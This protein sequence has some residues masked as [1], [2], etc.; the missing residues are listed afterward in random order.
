MPPH[1][2][3]PIQLRALTVP[4]RIAVAPMCQYSATDGVPEDWHL[5]NLGRFATAGPGLIFTEATGVEPDGRIT[6][7]CTGMYDDTTEAAWARIVGFIKS[8]GDSRVGMQLGHSGRKGNTVPPWEGGGLLEGEGAW[9]PQS[10][11]AVAYLPGWPEPEAMGPDDL[12]RVRNAFADAARRA[13][14]AGFDTV[15][16]H[17]AHGYLLHQFLSPVTNRRDDAYGGALENRMRFPLEVFDAV[18]DAFPDDKPVMVRLS[19]SDWIEGGWD[20]DGSVAFCRELKA[21]GCDMIDVTSGGIDQS[22]K[23]ETG[24]GYQ[25]DFSAQIRAEADIPTMAVGQITD[26]VQAETIVRTGQADMVALARG[27]LWD[28]NWTWKA[29]ET[30]GAE[31]AMPAP[32]ARC[33]PKLA[34]TPFV[35]RDAR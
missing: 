7:G 15:Q 34:S 23:I 11:S 4:N 32:Y 27:M 28:P 18:R 9:Q 26:P 16:L 19:A 10:A 13:D 5:V 21:R 24:P 20:I 14:R 6:P 29:A 22:Q 33:N 3:A 2:F 35:K 8:V 12:D 17:A 30:L 1:L 31:I 25:L